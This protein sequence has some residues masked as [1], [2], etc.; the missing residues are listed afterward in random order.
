MTSFVAA[1]LLPAG[2]EALLSVMVIEQRYSF[3]ALIMAATLGNT[4]GGLVTFAM[5][6]LARNVKKD[7][8]PK[9]TA[10]IERVRKYGVICLLFSWLPI[11]GDLLCFAAGWLKLNVFWSSTLLLLGKLMRYGV[12]ILLAQGVWG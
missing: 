2:S 11:V 9:Q 6:H 3:F 5:G 7:L 8:L 1:T 10:G 4:L 12:V